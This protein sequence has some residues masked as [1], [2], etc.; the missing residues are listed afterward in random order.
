MRILI[1]GS[2]DWPDDGS[3]HLL[4]GYH[5]GQLLGQNPRDRSGLTIVHGACPTGADAIAD[6]LGQHPGV[7]IERHPADW[8]AFGKRAGF[9]RNQVMV[10]LGADL[11]IAFIRRSSRGASH[12]AEQAEKA[13]IATVRYTKED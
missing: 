6:R 2:R 5:Y 8:E 4:I 12:T 11:C 10:N 13:G 3:V 1:T 7:T 9:V